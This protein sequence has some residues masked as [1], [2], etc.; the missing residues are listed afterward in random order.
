MN[1]NFDQEINRIGTSS[2]KWD[3]QKG[4]MTIIQSDA[5]A[6]QKG[7]DRLL[8]LWVADMDF[9]SPP[10]VIEALIA[11]A[12]HGIF[13]YTAAGDSYFEA[14]INWMAKHYGRQIKREWFVLS[15]GVVTALSILVQTFVA[16]G[17]KVLVQPPVYYPF[18]GAIENNGAEIVRNELLLEN[19]RYT[20]NFDDLAQKTA[21]PAVKMAILCSPHNPIGRVWTR[22]EL[23]RFGD[24]C[25]ANNVLV[26]SDEIH[27]DLIFPDHTFTSFASISEEFEQKSIVCTAPSKTFNLPGFKTSNIIIPNR[28]LR[29]QFQK[30]M[31][32]ASL[33][34]ANIFGIVATEAAYRHGEEWLKELLVYIAGNYHFMVDYIHKHLPMLKVLPLEGTY[35]AWVDCRALGLDADARQDLFLKKAR[36]FLDEGELFGSEGLGF[37]RFNLA[38]PRAI[39]AEALERMKSVIDALELA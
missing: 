27:C 13:G 7:A 6:A 2:V 29:L 11:R 30:T 36:L 28:Q 16:P 9:Q 12:Q 1:Y 33:M 24:I 25:L 4:N 20:M 18:Y 34:G 10:E 32:S 3:Y 19:G 17:K 8:P 22:E 26:I 21:D 15:P 37:E 38:C 5:C 35:L 39:L 23:T 14:V 31:E